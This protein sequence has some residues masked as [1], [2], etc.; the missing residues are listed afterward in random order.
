MKLFVDSNVFI[1]SLTD[2]PG[3]G[4]TAI[5]LLDSDHEFCTSILNLMEIRSVLMKKKRIEQDAVESVL[6][7]I[8]TTVD[9][10]A[11]EI[12]DQIAAYSL[13]EETVLYTLGCLLLALANDVEATMVSFDA[14]LCE[15]GAVPPDELVPSG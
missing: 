11:P 4:R 14:D 13:Q 2:E 7:D 15:H 9:I 5:Q 8:Y 6:S 1:A 10:Y 3:R 12:S